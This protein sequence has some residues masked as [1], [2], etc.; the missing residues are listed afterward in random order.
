MSTDVLRYPPLPRG[1]KR[2]VFLYTMLAAIIGGGFAVTGPLVMA[3]AEGPPGTRLA[4]A[5][6]ITV[7]AL[8]LVILPLGSTAYLLR[9]GS[10]AGWIMAIVFGYLM[11]PLIPIL[12]LIGLEVLVTARSAEVTYFYG[13]R[14]RHGQPMLEL[15]DGETT[16]RLLA[17]CWEN[18]DQPPRELSW[19]QFWTYL[20]L[21]RP[22]WLRHS[23]GDD[24][25]HLFRAQ[26]EL[27]RSGEIVWGHVVQANSLLFQP[28]NIDS[29][30][31]VIYSLDDPRGIDPRH[32]K[33]V[34][35]QL[36]AL[37]G[38]TPHDPQA[39]AIAD[40][41]TDEW[42][43]RFG[44]AVP[45]ELSG[46]VPMLLSTIFVSRRHLPSAFLCMS[47]IPLLVSPQPPHFAIPLPSLYWPTELRESWF[48]A[49]QQK[50]VVEAL[51]REWV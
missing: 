37:K 17:K 41:L 38:R 5:V 51:G 2:L 14:N 34:S 21:K 43:R 49:A 26:E 29:P 13:R 7:M 31:E 24:M 15:T 46:P 39:R 16:A 9:R 40:H 23:P 25:E 20:R 30:A 18:F 27:Y 28:G 8:V 22:P 48:E 32:L 1:A 12:S 3:L 4:S 10:H 19:W 50:R 42:T 36:S 35:R 11:L 45:T 44:L 47:L 6:I 33:H